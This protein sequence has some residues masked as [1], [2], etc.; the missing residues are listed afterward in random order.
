MKRWKII[1]LILA[2]VIVLAQ[3][4]SVY[5]RYK[6]SQITEKIEELKSKKVT[7]LSNYNDFNGVIHVHSFLGGHS[8]GTFD[9]L[10]SAANYNDLDFV[11]M[12]EHYSPSFDT[13]AMTLQGNH[14]KTLFVNG[15]EVDTANGD[16]FLLVSGSKD[17][18]SF[19]KKPTTEVLEKI[20]AENKLAIVA[21]P[22]KLNSW[23]ANF[24]GIEVFSLNTNA[25]KINP[26]SALS[27]LPWS[28]SKYP[29]LALS[30]HSIYP[31]E[32][33]RKFDE[34]SQKRKISVFG[35]SDAHS[36]IG[37]RLFGDQTGKNLFDLKLDPYQNILPVVQTHILLEKDKSFTQEN[38][39][40][41]LKNGRSFVGFDVLSDSSGFIFSAD[42]KI[43]GDE[44]TLKE[45][46]N[47]RALAP[48]ISHFILYRNGEKIHEQ[49]ETSEI[50]FETKERGTYR[51]E[52]YLDSLGNSFN[53]MP[54]I[55]SNPIYIK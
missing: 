46:V 20:H 3:I 11:I 6:L 48:Q 27:E 15:N 9:E 32:N 5:N 8:N 28:F 24:D 36:N 30:K 54:W 7:V 18:A 41:A 14:G 2:C 17:A 42:D 50:H 1:L 37:L 33:L 29:Q 53:S 31:T 13:S 40:Q 35:G 16:R 51:V 34:I 45:K 21:Y 55:L 47:L 12:T 26:L 10:V 38:L 4:P 49:S 19:A 44:I 25:K 23:D 43:M 22:E 39:L 52:V